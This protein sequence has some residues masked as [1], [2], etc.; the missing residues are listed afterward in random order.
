[1]G[2]LQSKPEAHIGPNLRIK[3]GL[4]LCFSGHL[5]SRMFI[6]TRSQ[7]ILHQGLILLRDYLLFFD[8]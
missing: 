6:I 4:R 7:G 5:K 1:M 2:I 8:T 3:N